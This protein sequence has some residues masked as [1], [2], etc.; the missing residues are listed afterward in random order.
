M[1]H[2][3]ISLLWRYIFVWS[4]T[5]SPQDPVVRLD[6]WPQRLQ[7]S[8][9][10]KVVGQIFGGDA[11]EAAHPFLKPAVIGI[12]VVDMKIGSL[13]ARVAGRWHDVSWDGGPSG[14]GNDSRAAVAAE[15]VGRRYNAAKSGGNGYPVQLGQDSIGGCTLAVS[16]HD[17]R[18]LFGGKATLGRLAAS[19]ARRARH[20]RSLP[21]V[22]F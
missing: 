5:D 21:F 6:L 8:A 19:L 14:K 22:R 3:S 20:I 17:H 13:R 12:D 7:G 1:Q 2:E 18:N 4:Q 11:V 9:P 10:A 15:L 16:R